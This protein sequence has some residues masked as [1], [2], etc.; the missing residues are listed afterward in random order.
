MSFRLADEEPICGRICHVAKG[1]GKLLLTNPDWSFAVVL[2][3][4]IVESQ[5]TE[6]LATVSSGVS[7]F[8]TA[9]E[10][11]LRSTPQAAELRQS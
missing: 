1:S 10:Q 8:N 7:L 11:A 5:L 2:H 3:Q 9:A 4:G 6:G